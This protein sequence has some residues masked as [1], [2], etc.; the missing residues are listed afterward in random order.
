[1]P[2]LE[3]HHWKWNR[4]DVQHVTTNVEGSSL[5]PPA[6]TICHMEKVILP[7]KSSQ[8]VVKDHQYGAA[9]ISRN[10]VTPDGEWEGVY[11]KSR[12]PTHLLLKVTSA[13]QFPQA[14][15]LGEPD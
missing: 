5:I 11:S 15:Q 7:L 3:L 9:H 1:M 12:S 6:I 14:F 4:S 10:Y 13:I 8:T 2:F